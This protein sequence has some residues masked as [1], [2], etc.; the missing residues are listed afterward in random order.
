MGH[1]PSGEPPHTPARRPREV[2]F[3]WLRL[4]PPPPH[5]W[6]PHCRNAHRALV[7]GR[8]GR[9]QA[10]DRPTLSPEPRPPLHRAPLETR[11]RH[12]RRSGGRSPRTPSQSPSRCQ[13]LRAN[14]GPGPRWWISDDS[15]DPSEVSEG[16]GHASAEFGKAE[17]ARNAQ[18]EALARRCLYVESLTARSPSHAAQAPPRSNCPCSTSKLP[19]Q[20]PLQRA[21]RLISAQWTVLCSIR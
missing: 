2:G 1:S 6:G 17:L 10:G 19:A 3:C 18:K 13:P 20:R 15:A 16:R 5:N 14:K 12:L 4:A 11:P 8:S 7:Q 9:L 21:G